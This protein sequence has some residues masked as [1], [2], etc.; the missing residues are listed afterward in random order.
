MTS[1]PN[2][3]VILNQQKMRLMNWSPLGLQFGPCKMIVGA[4]DKL[5]VTVSLN[6]PGTSLSFEAVAEV[7]RVAD[8]IVAAKYKCADPKIE[9]QIKALFAG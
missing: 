3:V 2:D 9:Q 4:G 5:K 8:G 7:L 6:N 1:G